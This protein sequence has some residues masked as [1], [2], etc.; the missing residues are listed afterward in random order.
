M[1]CAA[2]ELY[3]EE[4]AIESAKF[5][6]N[7]NNSPKDLPKQVQKEISNSV[8]TSKHEL[9]PLELSGDGWKEIY[10]SHV[11]VLTKKLNTPKSPVVDELFK[12]TVGIKNI[13]DQWTLGKKKIDDFVTARG[14]IAHRGRAAKYIKIWILNEYKKN[15]IYTIQETDNILADYLKNFSPDGKSPWRRRHITP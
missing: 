10:I 1:L 6:C 14:D 3:L 2:W 15:V 13:S 12:I 4:V 11:D 7:K 5:L 9:K 8:K